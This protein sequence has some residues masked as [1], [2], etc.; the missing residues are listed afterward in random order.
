M[1][2]PPPALS[3][4]RAARESFSPPVFYRKVLNGPLRRARGS[5]LVEPDR[6]QAH[7]VEDAEIGGWIETL[8]VIVPNL[9]DPLP[10]DRQQRRVL[11][12]DGFSLVNK[13]QTLS[14][15]NFLVDLCGQRLE[16]LVVPE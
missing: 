14:G 11:L 4:D 9:V 2:A 7:D 16:L 15:I 8:D 5:A 13:C 12:H 10:G 3:S 1:A 6:I